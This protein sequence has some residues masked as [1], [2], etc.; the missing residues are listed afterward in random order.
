MMTATGG[1]VGR[2]GGCQR[3]V[4]GWP[5]AG[6]AGFPR[7]A[8]PLEQVQGLVWGIRQGSTEEAGI[9]LWSYPP[10]AG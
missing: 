6:L 3:P 7:K 9:P 10:Q 5:L 8:R 4:Y 1:C 2:Q